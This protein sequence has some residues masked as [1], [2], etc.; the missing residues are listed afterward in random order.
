M[1]MVKM[2]GTMEK[3]VEIVAFWGGINSGLGF[4][5]K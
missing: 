3:I 2:Y 1:L 5:H 4:I